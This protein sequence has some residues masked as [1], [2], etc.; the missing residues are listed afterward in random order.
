MTDLK[1]LREVTEKTLYGLTADD[2]LKQRI[3]EKSIASVPKNKRIIRLVPV[4]SAVFTVLLVAA[5]VLNGLKPV[6]PA[7]PGDINVFTAGN[8]NSRNSESDFFQLI[9]Q[10]DFCDEII[11]IGIEKLGLVGNHDSCCELICT[12]LDNSEHSETTELS[13]PVMMTVTLKDGTN[14]LLEVEE[15]YIKQNG[16]CR[17]CAEFFSLFH[18]MVS[19]E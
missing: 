1:Q 17:K 2:T 18:Q 16:V 13:V 4:F 19:K 5:F 3:L 8:E 15:P 12:F 6:S 11:S 9:E 14:I 7:E 10:N